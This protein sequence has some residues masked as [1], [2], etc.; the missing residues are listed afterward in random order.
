MQTREHLD[1]LPDRSH[2]IVFTQELR[3][4]GWYNLRARRA[5]SEEIMKAPNSGSHNQ[6]ARLAPSAAKRWVHCTASIGLIEANLDRIP[7]DTGSVYADEGTKAHDFAEAVLTGRMTLAE[8]PDDFRPHIRD[9]TDR[10]LAL[11]PEGVKPYVEAKIP[12]FYA[13]QDTGTA[14]FCIVTE[15]L[16]ITRDLKYGAGVLVD[17]EDNEQLAIYNL[18]FIRDLQSDGIF[19]FHPATIVRMEIDQPRH[20]ADTPVRSWELTLSELEMFCRDIEYSAIQIREKRGLKFAPS[21]DA[22]RW[23]PAK[24]FCEPRAKMLTEVFDRPGVAGLD[25]LAMLP[26]LTKDEKKMD[27]EDRNEVR[28]GVLDDETLVRIF[29]NSKGITAWLADVAEYLDARAQS[30]S[31]VEGTKLVMGREGNR[32]WTDVELADKFLQQTAKLKIEERY[33]MTLISPTQAEAMLEPDNRSTRFKNV[34]LGLIGRSPAKKVL[35]L[36]T[37]KRPS[38]ASALDELPDLDVFGH[39]DR[40]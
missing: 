14:D 1:V 22:C 21:T 25:V 38:V 17:A 30:G 28:G 16:V 33:K 12:L 8:V 29:Q 24:G 15:D 13:P 32:E 19:D 18:S 7:E 20:H 2:G 9:Y 39:R 23:C 3:P 5:T 40:G 26:D 4:T 27:V 34:F 36:A 31:P 37:D 10:C 11:V 6:H 35:A